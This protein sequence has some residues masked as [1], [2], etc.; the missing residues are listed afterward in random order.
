MLVK[1]ASILQRFQIAGNPYNFTNTKKYK[2]LY[3]GREKYSG[4]VIILLKWAISIQ[5][6]NVDIDKTMDMVQRLNVSGSKMTS[7]HQ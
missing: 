3:F 1:Y 5:D 6:P 7:H 2:K 4:M